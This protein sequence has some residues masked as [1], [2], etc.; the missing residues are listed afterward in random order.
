MKI[1][2]GQIRL[3][4]I[5]IYIN[6]IATMSDALHYTGTRPLPGNND[7]Y[8]IILTYMDDKVITEMEREAPQ[9]SLLGYGGD[10]ERV[11]HARAYARLGLDYQMRPFNQGGDYRSIY[12]SIVTHLDDG[13]R[14][15]VLAM[16]Q[17]RML[18]KAAEVDVGSIDV[19][20]LLEWDRAIANV[21]L[22]YVDYHPHVNY[23][24]WF[25][26]LCRVYRAA[27]DMAAPCLVSG[28][29]DRMGKIPPSVGASV[30]D[31][32]LGECRVAVDGGSYEA[33]EPNRVIPRTERLE[34]ILDACLY[35]LWRVRDSVAWLYPTFLKVIWAKYGEEYRAHV[36]KVGGVDLDRLMADDADTANA[37]GR[38]RSCMNALFAMALLRGPAVMRTI[39][40]EMG[41]SLPK[42]NVIYKNSLR[43]LGNTEYILHGSGTM[44]GAVVQP[45]LSN[46]TASLVYMAREHGLYPVAR[47]ASGIMEHDMMPSLAAGLIGAY[48]G[49]A[50]DAR[51]A[52]DYLT[53]VRQLWE[54]CLTVDASIRNLPPPD[55]V[56]RAAVTPDWLTR[57]TR[58]LVDPTVDTTIFQVSMSAV[59]FRML[60]VSTL[61]AGRD[62]LADAAFSEQSHVG[63]ML[64][65]L[66]RVP[67]HIHGLVVLRTTVVGGADASYRLG[68]VD[69]LGRDGRLSNDLYAIVSDLCTYLPIDPIYRVCQ[70][71]HVALSVAPYRMPQDVDVAMSLSRLPA[72]ATVDHVVDATAVMIRLLRERGRIDPRH[73]EYYNAY[74]SLMTE[75]NV[76]GDVGLY[77]VFGRIVVA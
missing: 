18:T 52:I 64:P 7:L 72:A 12:L 11:W 56:M 2:M 57:S 19:D 28:C 59:A 75:A 22:T 50:R 9:S 41:E 46:L 61:L 34:A 45:H 73:P 40:A 68:R 67:Q 55:P 8:L 33:A 69:M 63:N 3:H 5:P 60:M 20:R 32:W 54:E 30:V 16:L 26:T 42:M 29:I 51:E 17:D 58:I 14:I 71:L 21:L 53:T 10:A 23:A 15:L 70:R 31:S 47:I 4:P 13:I 39:I 77:R 24:A 35:S 65:P 27:T 43:L 25:V 74:S 66:A 37:I 1:V 36:P 62:D 44:V 38:I 6:P 48:Y 49:L 76:L